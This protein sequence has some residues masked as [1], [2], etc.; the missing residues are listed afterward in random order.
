ME[1]FTCGWCEAK[2][3]RPFGKRGRPR[4][5]CSVQCRRRA[6]HR[7][8]SASRECE[9][10]GCSRAHRARGMC[11]MHWRRWARA[12]GREAAPKWDARRRDAWKAREAL[13]RGAEGA[14]TFS[15]GEVFERD[16]WRCGIC[17]SQVNP[18]LRYPDP[19][20]ASL[21]HIVPLAKGGAHSLANAQLAHLFCNLSKGDRAIAYDAAI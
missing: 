15:Y 20:S 12:Q 17:S 11:S 19:M 2:A 6:T 5:Y 9:V 4:K 10:G 14:E 21:D 7:P 8:D 13:K 16:E 3:L 18:E 1:E